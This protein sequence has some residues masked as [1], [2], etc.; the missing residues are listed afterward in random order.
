MGRCLTCRQYLIKKFRIQLKNLKK[1]VI[2]KYSSTIINF[3]LILLIIIL[4]SI[5]EYVRHHY[6]ELSPKTDFN[7]SSLNKSD[8]SSAF[9]GISLSKNISSYAGG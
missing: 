2:A 6:Q 5:F 1:I 9:N 7:S 4:P 8:K 3:L